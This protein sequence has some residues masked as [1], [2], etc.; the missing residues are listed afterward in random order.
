M[1]R[2]SNT[3][4]SSGFAES[5]VK[6]QRDWFND[7]QSLPFADHIKSHALVSLVSK[8]LQYHQC[9]QT[10][11]Q[12]CRVAH[13]FEIHSQF[14]SLKIETYPPRQ[15][16][17]S[18][19]MPVERHPHPNRSKLKMDFK[20]PREHANMAGNLRLM[21]YPWICLLQRQRQSEAVEAMVPM[22]QLTATTATSQ[23]AKA[24]KL[25]TTATTIDSMNRQ[26]Q[27]RQPNTPPQTMIRQ[28]MAWRLTMTPMRLA[29]Q[30]PKTSN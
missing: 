7:P 10:L 17:F 19:L 25:I 29:R 30:L 11:N 24:C 20:N 6:L 3:D 2:I 9:E 27:Y 5:A 16:S 21:D 8:G 4:T 15:R 22:F 12:V 14:D 26:S 28:P 23:T 18:G 13:V 1:L